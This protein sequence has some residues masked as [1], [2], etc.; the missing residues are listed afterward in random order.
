MMFG[1]LDAASSGIC[2][3]VG[4]WDSSTTHYRQYNSLNTVQFTTLGTT[5]WTQYNSL[6]QQCLLSLQAFVKHSGTA[7]GVPTESLIASSS[8]IDTYTHVRAYRNAGIDIQTKT[9]GTNSQDSPKRSVPVCKSCVPTIA[10]IHPCRCVFTLVHLFTIV[11]VFTHHSRTVAM[12]QPCAWDT[13]HSP[14]Q[15]Q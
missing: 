5:H 4:L 13:V 12:K 15:C 2:S 9:P 11:P 6:S 10:C 8:C 7:H 1:L 14:P 3:T